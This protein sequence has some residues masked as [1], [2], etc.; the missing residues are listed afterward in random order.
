M[1][2]SNSRLR[3]AA[4]I[5][6]ATIPLSASVAQPSVSGTYL[7]GNFFRVSSAAREE[8]INWQSLPSGSGSG[9]VVL[10]RVREN[11]SLWIAHVEATGADSIEI[12]VGNRTERIGNRRIPCP[13]VPVGDLPA[14][15]DSLVSAARRDVAPDSTGV[16]MFRGLVLLL[17]EPR[18]PQIEIQAAIAL[19][20][21]AEF[22][23]V[24]PL[25]SDV[26]Y[27]VVLVPDDHAG[28]AVARA[29]R[30]VRASPFVR[31]AAP[32]RLYLNATESTRRP[33]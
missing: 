24:L 17:F 9:T 33:Y 16:A 5:I 29:I 27:Y 13:S 20:P 30:T 10:S 26:S 23:G 18:T 19:V 31:A 7:C 15:P 28:G 32:Y 6:C 3:Y 12:S 8:Q 22:V 21:H 4:L 11:P 25:A 14:L 1:S 2:L